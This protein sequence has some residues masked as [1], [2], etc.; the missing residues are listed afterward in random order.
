MN[1][2]TLILIKAGAIATLA[3]GSY[4]LPALALAAPPTNTVAIT[5][6]GKADHYLKEE[7]YYR[8]RM[9]VDEKHS[10]QLFT[11]ANYFHHK[12]QTFRLAALDAGAAPRL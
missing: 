5:A 12:A 9:R 10:I 7:A 8:A 3:M 6:A 4:A 1:R 11:L 2:F